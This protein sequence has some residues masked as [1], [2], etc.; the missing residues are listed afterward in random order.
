MIGHDEG[1][2]GVGS[3][4]RPIGAR[5]RDAWEMEIPDLSLLPGGKLEKLDKQQKQLCLLKERTHASW[6]IGCQGTYSV[7]S[8][9]VMH[10]ASIATTCYN[11]V[12]AVA[13]TGCCLCLGLAQTLSHPSSSFPP[14]RQHPA[15]VNATFPA[16]LLYSPVLERCIASPGGHCWL[17][18][19][20]NDAVDLIFISRCEE[21]YF[22]LPQFIPSFCRLSPVIRSRRPKSDPLYIPPAGLDLS[23]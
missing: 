19:E 14:S 6:A 2:F 23:N 11:E 22:C 1:S 10:C 13:R 4:L 16:L 21:G 5:E 20:I 3:E 17:R 9:T 12:P 7:Y 18:C 15:Q 8:E